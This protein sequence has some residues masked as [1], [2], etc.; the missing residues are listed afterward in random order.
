MLSCS[1]EESA[2]AGAEMSERSEPKFDFK[3]K[4]YADLDD[5]KVHS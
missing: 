5:D 2:A 3:A 4:I 1:S